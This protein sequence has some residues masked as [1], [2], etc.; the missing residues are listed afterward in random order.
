MLIIGF[1]ITRTLH[2]HVPK[3]VLKKIIIIKCW[4]MISSLP[5]RSNSSTSASEIHGDV[6]GD[7]YKVKHTT[8]RR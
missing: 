5:L 3:D 8:T 6:D 1:N 4:K 2:F 7:G